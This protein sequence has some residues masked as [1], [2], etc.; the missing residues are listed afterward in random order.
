[1]VSGCVL[2]N[3]ETKKNFNVFWVVAHVFFLEHWAYDINIMCITAAIHKD[4]L[5]LLVRVY[6]VRLGPF[7]GRGREVRGEMSFTR[8]RRQMSRWRPPDWRDEGGQ[9]LRPT[10]PGLAARRPLCGRPVDW[11]LLTAAA[12]AAAVG[13]LG[14]SSIACQLG[15]TAHVLHAWSLHLSPQHPSIVRRHLSVTWS[16]MQFLITSQ[17]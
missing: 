2:T 12:A 10:Y 8:R 7:R 16:S 1:M 4:R 11:S 17:E 3:F 5:L 6:R 15:G 13:S 14:R 9:A